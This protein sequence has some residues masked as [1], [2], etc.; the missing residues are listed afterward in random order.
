MI[1]RHGDMNHILRGATWLLG[2]VLLS[3]CSGLSDSLTGH[4]RPVADAAG[5]TLGAEELA[6]VMA[7]SPMP[8][9]TLTGHW[10][11]EIARLWADYVTLAAVYAPIGFTSGLTGALFREFAFTLAGAVVVSGPT[12]VVAVGWEAVVLTWPPPGEAGPVG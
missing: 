3:S 11:G 5:H 7:V 2:A 10:S 6:A 12:V 4:A 1:E 9:S 8:D